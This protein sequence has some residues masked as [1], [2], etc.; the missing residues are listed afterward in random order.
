MGMSSVYSSVTILEIVYLSS[1]S[2][3]FCDLVQVCVDFGK[4]S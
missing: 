1:F 2:S 3:F 4:V